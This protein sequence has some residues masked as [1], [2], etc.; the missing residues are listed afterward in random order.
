MTAVEVGI[1]DV[2]RP[3]AL[4]RFNAKF[5]QAWFDG[6]VGAR[7]SISHVRLGLSRLQ[8]KHCQESR[9][10]NRLECQADWFHE[11]FPG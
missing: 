4:Q 6:L 9:G 1:H 2:D 10:G 8:H 7:R 5:K 3:V 11:N